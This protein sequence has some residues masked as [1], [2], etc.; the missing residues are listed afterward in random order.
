MPPK[1]KP[2]K[3]KKPLKAARG[4]EGFCAMSP[5]LHAAGAAPQAFAIALRCCCKK[6]S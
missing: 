3:E 6:E 2:K 4:H 1:M 5:A